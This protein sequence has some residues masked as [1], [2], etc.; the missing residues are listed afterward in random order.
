M[1]KS[2]PMIDA[3]VFLGMHH[4]DERIR[5]DSLTFFRAHFQQGARMNFEQVG[6]CDAVI[7][8][9]PREVQDA[10]YPFMDV[11][12]S[13]MKIKREG[14]SFHE[15]EFAARD[16]RRHG[17]Y[18]HQALLVAQ[19]L[20]DGG[21]LYTHDPALRTLSCLHGLLGDFSRLD[22][23]TAF[24]DALEALYQPSRIYTH[25]DKDWDHVETRHLHPLDHTA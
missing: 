24:P 18:P 3:T 20:N 8:R 19:V 12:H 9:Q 1:A 17:L 7:W 4:E 22:T 10:Y 6:I 5:Q 23:G 2:M 21:V 15:I 14:Y 13:E 25:T 11:L 16:L